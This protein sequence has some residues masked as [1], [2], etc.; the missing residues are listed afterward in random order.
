MRHRVYLAWAAVAVAALSACSSSG[1]AID[2]VEDAKESVRQQKD[3]ADPEWKDA[4]LGVWYSVCRAN[5]A[6]R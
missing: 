6:V 4:H 2:P 3:C 1:N 5:A